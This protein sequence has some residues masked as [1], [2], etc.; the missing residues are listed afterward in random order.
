M[1]ASCCQYPFIIREPRATISPTS[2]VVT[3]LPS[4]STIITST[5]SSGLPMEVRRRSL[6]STSWGV[7]SNSWSS[8]GSMVMVDAVSVWPKAFMNRTPGNSAIACRIT[9]KGMGA[10]P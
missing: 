7:P 5:S 1:A 8:G 2:P 6:V 9:G 4:S 3:G 10:A